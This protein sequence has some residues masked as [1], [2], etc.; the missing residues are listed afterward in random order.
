MSGIARRKLYEEV[1]D[2]LVAAIGAAEFP[3]GTQLPSER[4]LMARYGVGRPAVREAMLTLQQWGLIRISHGERAR[5]VTPTPDAIVE[6]VSGAMVSMLAADPRGLDNLKEARRMLEVGLVRLAVRRATVAH[7]A[8]L[9]EAQRALVAAAGDRGAFVAADMA[10][11]GLIAE[12]SGNTIIAATTRG[13]LGWLTRFKADLVSVRGAERLTIA[14]HERIR[15]AIAAGDADAAAEA[16]T[17]HLT[18][19]DALYAQLV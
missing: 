2:R 16:M 8:A 12:I 3:P 7:L 19:A 10:F 14:E 18:R 5:V 13:L 9:D 6:G 15:R 11:H 4:E 1:L 17:A